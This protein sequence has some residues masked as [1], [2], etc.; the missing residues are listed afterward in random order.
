LPPEKIDEPG[1]EAPWATPARDVAAV[2]RPG[3]P[4]CPVAA[5]RE[6]EVQVRALDVGA[7]SDELAPRTEP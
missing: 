2:P 6:G 3:P 4:A 1:R 7:E 5:A